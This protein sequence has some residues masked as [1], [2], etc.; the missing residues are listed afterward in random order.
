MSLARSHLT[1]HS[2][3]KHTNC[4]HHQSTVPIRISDDDPAQKK[5]THKHKH[6]DKEINPMKR[7]GCEMGLNRNGRKMKMKVRLKKKD[8]MCERDDELQSTSL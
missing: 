1:Q 5:N 3:G 8:G 2:T 7:N 4:H 6:K